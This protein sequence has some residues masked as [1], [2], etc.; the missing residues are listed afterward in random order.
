MLTNK[1]AVI[2]GSTGGVGLAIA[3]Q[4]AA[5]GAN[6]VLHGLGDAQAIE[7]LRINIE[8]QHDVSAYYLP[9]DLSHAEAIRQFIDQAVQLAGSIDILVNN[10]DI[11]PTASW[12][13]II[14]LHLSSAFHATAEALP[15]MQSK[16]WG[17]VITIA[18]TTDLAAS[19]QH[20]AYAAAKQ[21]VLGMTKAL[22]V[23]YA[24]TGISCNAICVSLPC[25][26]P[27]QIGGAAVFLSSEAA[28]QMS[29]TA[30][31]YNK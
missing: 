21:G 25:A 17:R 26:L 13:E 2:T 30:L 1:T 12:A 15:H 10:A 29:G 4:L 23:E 6:V 8:L 28:A 9:A 7:K 18:P 31:N 22:G 20:A 19:E 5:H 14:A 27:E 11:Q 16:G 24:N 3:Q